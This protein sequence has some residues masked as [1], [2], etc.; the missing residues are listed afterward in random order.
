MSPEELAARLERQIRT[1]RAYQSTAPVY[2]VLEKVLADV[3]E[4]ETGPRLVPDSMS[5]SERWIT[6]KQAAERIGMSPEFIY[7]HQ[8]TLTWVKRRGAK[9][10]RCDLQALERWNDKKQAAA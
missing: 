10:L 1:E 9:S 8:K 4:L 7:Q 5:D 6:V 3:R 2:A